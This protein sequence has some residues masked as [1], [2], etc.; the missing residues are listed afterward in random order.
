MVKELSGQNKAL[1]SSRTLIR[2]ILQGK[3]LHKYSRWWHRSRVWSC[4]CSTA[5]NVDSHQFN[6]QSA[7]T[8][9]RYD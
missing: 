5:D 9:L 2:D 8:D 7:W 1:S 3:N 6:D 4:V